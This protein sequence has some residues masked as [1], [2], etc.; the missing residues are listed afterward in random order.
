M[1]AARSPAAEATRAAILA[2]ARAWIGTPYCHQASCRGAGTDC[3]GLVRGVWRAVY[4]A[5]P[6]APPPYTPDWAE[7]T[8]AETLMAA[9]LRHL[10]AIPPAEAAAGDLVLFRMRARGPAKHLGILAS[11]AIAGGR[12]VHAYSGAAVCESHLTAPWARR[13]AGVFRFPER[14]P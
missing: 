3:L 6:E 7:A 9:A 2:E 8:G 13:I 1:T 12:I 14:S 4:G 11:P 5:E 10:T